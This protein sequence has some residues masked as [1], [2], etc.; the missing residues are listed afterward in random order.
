ML[1]LGLVSEDV[2]LKS[3]LRNEFSQD[4]LLVA[5]TQQAREVRE[6]LASA[7]TSLDLVILDIELIRGEGLAFL[8]PFLPFPFAILPSAV[9]P[10]QAR[11]FIA[12]YQQHICGY[13][14][15]HSSDFSRMQAIRSASMILSARLK[16]RASLPRSHRRISI[17]TTQRHFYIAPD[18]LMMVEGDRNY[19]ELY[20]GYTE[21]LRLGRKQLTCS[22]NLSQWERMIR[23][24]GIPFLKRVSRKHVI[25][26]QFLTEWN[27]QQNELILRDVYE[28]HGKPEF[29]TCRAQIGPSYKQALGQIFENIA[30]Y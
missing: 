3:L 27:K 2:S 26:A 6:W 13:L 4:F 8:E 11:E 28:Q 20:F 18:G 1:R 17:H 23:S 24:L 14:D 12:R 16:E 21:S 9:D 25:N 10:E 15:K 30:Q 29:L 22:Y 5:E 7:H 19:T